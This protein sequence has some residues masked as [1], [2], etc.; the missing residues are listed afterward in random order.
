[1]AHLVSL[2][3]AAHRHISI[4]SVRVEVLGAKLN[5]VPVVLTEFLKLVVQY[6]IAF[7][8][9]KETGRFVCVALF[10]FHDNENLFVDNGRWNAFYVP[11][12]ISRQP[13]FLGNAADNQS[14]NDQFVVCIDVEHEGIEP[15]EGERIFDDEG[16]ETAYLERMKQGL[17]ELLNGELP[18]QQFVQSL[19]RLK[20][21]LPMKLEITF[22]NAESTQVEGLYT[23]NETQLAALAADDIASLHAQ[24]YLGPIY[25]MLASLGHI[26]GMVDRRNKRL[27]CVA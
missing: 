5:M 18:T 26:Y 14:E 7:T 24:Q 3:N 12:H 4:D 11:L 20:L 25:T 10:G 27:A 17:A 15:G 6:P 22:E 2:D 9:D 19:A 8:K 16:N 13:F 23:I 1:M 21:L